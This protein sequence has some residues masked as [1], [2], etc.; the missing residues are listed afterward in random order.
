MLAEAGANVVVN[1]FNDPAG[2]NQQLAGQVADSIGPNALAVAADI[3]DLS[4]VTAMIEQ[5]VERFGALDIVVNNA[6]VISDKTAKKMSQE[7]WQF[8]ID[9]NLTGTFN[10]C[11]AAAEVLTD[12][13]RIVS[14]SSIS[15][16]L[17]FFGQSN[18]ASAKAGVIALT[19]VLSKELAKRQITVNAVAPGVVLTEM[20]LTIPEPVREEM[21]KE[22]PLGRFG[23]PEEI[24]SVIVFL[25]S[26]LAS[27]VTGQVVH[28]NGGWI[29]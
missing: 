23:T 16:V 21:L 28:I 27:Y 19:K 13:G 15:A 17:G 24:A 26:P 2:K 29:G 3:R 6:G 9:T 11:K 1:F 12:G 18:Y 8:V 20:G 7:Q 25:C 14:V 4:E 22:I 5:S 10:V